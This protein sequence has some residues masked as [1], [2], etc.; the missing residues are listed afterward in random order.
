MLVLRPLLRIKSRAWDLIGAG[1]WREVVSAW[2]CA[3][4]GAV[5]RFVCGQ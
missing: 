4:G 5:H 3:Q 1:V 2:F